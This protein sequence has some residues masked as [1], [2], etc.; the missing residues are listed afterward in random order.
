M[1]HGNRLWPACTLRSLMA[2]VPALAACQLQLEPDEGSWW[3]G[4]DDGS[5]SARSGSGSRASRGAR[6]PGTS[7]AP[8]TSGGARETSESGEESPDAVVGEGELV[9][10]ED[11]GEPEEPSETSRAG[12]PAGP[13]PEAYQTLIVLDP[14]LV[15]GPLASNADPTAPWS[16]RR[17]L[18]WLAGPGADSLEFTRA[19]LERWATD[20]EVG[21]SYAPV[22]ARAGLHERFIEPWLGAAP[23][24][25]VQSAGY[26][27]PAPAAPAAADWADAP[28]RL[29]AIV[30]RIDLA[31]SA[32]ERG[33][34]G[35]LRYVYAMLDP[36][37]G[38]SLE[39]TLII[40]IPY[41]ATKPT[42]E[43]ARAW[44]DL[45]LLE[46]GEEYT[47]A[48]R[49]LTDEVARDAEPLRARV[50]TNEVAFAPSDAFT[51]ELREFRPTLND[52][53]LE[54]LGAPLEHTP[55]ADLEPSVLADY[56]VQH[57]DEV[58]GVGA[59][60]PTEMQAGAAEVS[61]ADFSWPVLGVSESS[62]TAFSR[63]TCNGC[64]GGDSAA[65]PFQHIAPGATAEAPAQVSRFLYDPAAE[66]DELWRRLLRLDELSATEC[67][68]TAVGYPSETLR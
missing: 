25:D 67:T 16:F 60:L 26:Y 2:L 22:G 15:N 38:R 7:A 28:F 31:D 51:W 12:A 18:S 36:E 45:E 33:S 53:A 61:A 44:A 64:H 49:T 1:K 47:T 21:P 66:S 5:T 68:T 58:R 52:D 8:D 63:Q 56:V 13:L 20:T 19:W 43:W 41:P 46:P 39:A 50:R 48:L 59:A 40:E 65:L 62:R 3:S 17:Q 9:S 54:L 27:G 32:C 37:T 11:A 34:A 29:I 10:P 57:I 42:A 4:D 30:N 35:E 6:R 24:S 55:R 14:G 23:E